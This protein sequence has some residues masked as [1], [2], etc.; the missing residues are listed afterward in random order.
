MNEPESQS[1]YNSESLAAL[2]QETTTSQ[3]LA[4]WAKAAAVR[5]IKTAAQAAIAGI[6]TSALAIGQVNWILIAGTAALS[7]VI[8]LITSIA[9]IPEVSDGDGIKQITSK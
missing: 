2:A 4:Q 8:S 7:G 3:T 1:E 5:A 9:G 6:P